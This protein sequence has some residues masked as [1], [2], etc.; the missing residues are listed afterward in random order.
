MRRVVVR[1]DLDVEQVV[2]GLCDGQV[3]P[4]KG[5]GVPIRPVRRRPGN[6]ST[7]SAAASGTAIKTARVG[8]AMALTYAQCFVLYRF[9]RR[10]HHDVDVQRIL[11]HLLAA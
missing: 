7:H 8:G 11:R 5:L 9:A 2:S 3:G 6:A 10:H 4:G 1:V